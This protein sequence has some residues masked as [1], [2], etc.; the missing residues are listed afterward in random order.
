MSELSVTITEHH[1]EFIRQAIARCSY[2]NASEIV[3][4]AQSL[5]EQLKEEYRLNLET[6]RKIAKDAFD[7]LD[8][9]EGHTIPAGGV[10]EYLSGLKQRARQRL[11]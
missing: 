8:R 2:S 10:R 3:S 6:L 4:D 1:R 9:G 5:L 11:V 7:V